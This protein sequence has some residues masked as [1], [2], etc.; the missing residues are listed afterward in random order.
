MKFHV[1]QNFRVL[2][3]DERVLRRHRNL[4]EF[5]ILKILLTRIFQTDKYTKLSN[6]RLVDLSELHKI[7]AGCCCVYSES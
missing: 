5:A 1:Q 6:S 7:I 3:D 4:R 2:G